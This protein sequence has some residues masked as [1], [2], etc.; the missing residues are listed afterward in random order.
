[1]KRFILLLLQKTVL[2]S[3]NLSVDKITKGKKFKMFYSTSPWSP[4][5]GYQG[6]P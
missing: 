1:M 2:G 5:A 3:Q 4:I 6:T